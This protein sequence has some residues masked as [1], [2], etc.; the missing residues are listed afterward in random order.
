MTT[1]PLPGLR[2]QPVEGLAD[3]RVALE[4]IDQIWRPPPGER[5]VSL[6]VLRATTHAGNYCVLARD[7]ERP[8]GVSYGF[9]GLHGDLSLHS[10]ITGVVPDLVGRHVGRALKLHQRDWALQRGIEVITWTYDPLIRRN[11]YFNAARLGALPVEYL[12]D[13]Y[14]EMTDELNAGQPTD[15]LAVRWDLRDP[16]VVA[17]CQGPLS[18]LA[19]GS[20]D[21]DP[22]AMA[23]RAD[24]AGAPVMGL[25]TRPDL[26]LVAVPHDIEAMRRTDPDLA[27]GWRLAVREILGGLLDAGW[28]V[29]GVLRDGFYV[30]QRT[31]EQ[32]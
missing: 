24:P 5:P 8:V 20:P 25:P 31:E 7:G 26:R 29:S 32:S 14:G 18:P 4:V 12:I 2:I 13:F 1:R 9:L 21:L 6:A 3:L 22:D 27:R 19:A 28:R 10:H 16:A 11:A 23:L 15:R 17:L 30:M